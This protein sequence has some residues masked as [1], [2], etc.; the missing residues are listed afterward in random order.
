MIKSKNIT[1][2]SAISQKRGYLGHKYILGSCKDID[3]ILF[4][5]DIIMHYELDQQTKIIFVLDN[6]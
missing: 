3:F 1:I 5:N 4:L 6:A 2:I